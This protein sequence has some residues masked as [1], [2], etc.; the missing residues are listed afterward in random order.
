MPHVLIIEDMFL[1]RQYLSDIA[2]LAGAGSVAL[3][4]TQDD[5]VASAR[6]KAPDLILSDLKLS[7]GSGLAAIDAILADHGEIPVI[8]ITGYPERC[9]RY[10]EQGRMLTKPV[11]PD[12]LLHTIRAAFASRNAA[13]P[14]MGTLGGIFGV[15]PV[16]G[17]Q[18]ANG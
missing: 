10:V 11:S 13:A 1:F 6:G 18:H 3:A 2:T 17:V 9:D 14:T 16:G 12:V 7:Q 8:I 5:A 4:S 15:Q